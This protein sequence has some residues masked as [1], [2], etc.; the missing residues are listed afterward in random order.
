[1]VSE[2]LHGRRYGLVLLH[3]PIQFDQW[4]PLAMV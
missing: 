4:L 1:L 3:S 2:N